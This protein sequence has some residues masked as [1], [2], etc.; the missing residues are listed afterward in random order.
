SRS[1]YLVLVDSMKKKSE[2]SQSAHGMQRE[3]QCTTP[4]DDYRF[5]FD[6]VRP[7]VRPEF[8]PPIEEVSLRCKALAADVEN[9]AA[10]RNVKRPLFTVGNLDTADRDALMITDSTLTLCKALAADVENVS[11]TRNVKR[12]LFTVGNHDTAD[13]DAVPISRVF[14][15]FRN[16]CMDNIQADSMTQTS[17]SDVLVNASRLLPSSEDNLIATRSVRNHGITDGTVVPF[18]RI[19]AR[20]RNMGMD[21]F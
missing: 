20:F 16:M 18:S 3:M 15:H 9:V 17:R 19:F 13:R 21:D 14:D 10:T 7:L 8:T 12:P 2:H 5:N 4:T 6:S 1:T 11:A